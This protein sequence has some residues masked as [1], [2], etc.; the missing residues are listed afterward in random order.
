MT[1]ADLLLEIAARCRR[2]HSAA[3]VVIGWYAAR[4]PHEDLEALLV[5]LD[6]TAP[7]RPHSDHLAAYA[8][9]WGRLPGDRP[10]P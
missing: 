8:E 10:Q 7:R 3:L 1:D 5:L 6:E 2:D 4:A 9:R